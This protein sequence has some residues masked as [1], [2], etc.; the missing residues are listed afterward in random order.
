M[1]SHGLHVQGTRRAIELSDGRGVVLRLCESFAACALDQLRIE[2]QVNALAIY[3]IE[4]VSSGREL[5]PAIA[6]ELAAL[7]RDR[8]LPTFCRRS[9][10]SEP[11]GS[12]TDSC[13]DQANTLLEILDN[14]YYSSPLARDLATIDH[15]LRLMVSRRVSGHAMNCA[16]FITRMLLGE[17]CNMSVLDLRENLFRRGFLEFESFQEACETARSPL[18][19]GMEVSESPNAF[20]H[21]F[22]AFVSE[23]DPC[24]PIMLDVD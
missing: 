22:L 21:C 18:V 15:C 6:D 12:S 13:G 4:R 19:V 3:W 7:L 8:I 5:S 1:T 10:W 16:G 17:S 23:R 14:G 11:S 9:D 24:I 20:H 2:D